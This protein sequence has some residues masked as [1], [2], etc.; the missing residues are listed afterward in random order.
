LL[1]RLIVRLN[2][3]VKNTDEAWRTGV[4]L[5]RSDTLA[6]VIETRGEKYLKIQAKGAE[7][8]EL[9]TI[10]SEEIDRLNAGYHRLKVEKQVPCICPTC[11]GMEEPNFYDYEDLMRRRKLGKR[12][13][14]C[15]NSFDDVDVLRLLDHLFI[16]TFFKPRTLQVFVSY[17]K[18]DLAHLEA[19]KKHLTVLRREGSLLAWDDT[20]L[21]PGEEWDSRI[22]QQ[23]S[24][25]DI[26]ILLVSSDFMATEY[27][28]EEINI[29]IERHERG[30]A[31][32]VPVIVRACDWTSAP[33][34]R[35]SALPAKGKPITKWSD[36]DEAWSLVVKGLRELS[37][38]T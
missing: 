31:I 34:S 21:V 28:W 20:Q 27:I 25:A 11:R 30:E 6:R 4:V 8:R 18:A 26:I 35:F 7:S 22:R 2:R 14:E 23:L 19:L 38:K 36:P 24:T 37:K 15:R 33:F 10:I 13:I 32:V 29:A 16:T 1:S 17:S 12:T 3:Y 5:E 9:I